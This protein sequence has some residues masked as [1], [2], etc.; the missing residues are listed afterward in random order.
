MSTLRQ[1]EVSLASLALA[2]ANGHTPEQSAAAVAAAN[3]RTVTGVLTSRPTSRDIKIDGFSMGLNGVE[4]IQARACSPIRA[5]LQSALSLHDVT[6]AF[7]FSSG[8]LLVCD[9]ASRRHRCTAESCSKGGLALMQDC[10]IELTIGRRYG[11]LGSNGSGKSNFLQCLA[12]REACSPP[13]LSLYLH[14]N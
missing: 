5:C 13:C 9:C 12:A 8:V 1:S 4:L 2:P 3:T 10:S 11:L 6:C 14:C 7:C